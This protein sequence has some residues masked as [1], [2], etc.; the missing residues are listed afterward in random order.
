MIENVGAREREREI[1]RSARQHVRTVDD[2]V[3]PFSVLEQS[4]EVCLAYRFSRHN[5]HLPSGR[6]MHYLAD[7]SDGSYVLVVAN[8]R[9]HQSIWRCQVAHGCV[10]VW[11]DGKIHKYNDA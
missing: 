9:L 8:I 1:E 5:N 3:F 2:A 10:G 7:P 6:S 11:K 4:A